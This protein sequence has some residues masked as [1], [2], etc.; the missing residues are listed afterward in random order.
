MHDRNVALLVQLDSLALVTGVGVV[1]PAEG[2]DPNP[3]PIPNP[4]PDPKPKPKPN[5]NPSPNP[6]PTQVNPAE[7]FDCPVKQL[8]AFAFMEDPGGL[9]V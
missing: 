2:F 9:E 3:N 4:N 6:I 7:G 8:L 5:A 1:N